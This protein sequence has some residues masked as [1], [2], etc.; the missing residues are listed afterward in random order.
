[1]LIDCRKR[2]CSEVKKASLKFDMLSNVFKFF[3]NKSLFWAQ[4]RPGKYRAKLVKTS[5]VVNK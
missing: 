4:K 5:L 3:I 1:M 2:A